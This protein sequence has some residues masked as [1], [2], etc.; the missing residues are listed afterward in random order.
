LPYSQLFAVRQLIAAWCWRLVAGGLIVAAGGLHLA[1]LLH[2]CPLDLAPDEAHY[3]DWSRHLDWSYYSKGPLVAYLIRA[4]VG[5]AGSWSQRMCGSEMPAVRLPAIA[6]GSLL[7]VSL[8]VL[9]LQVYQRERLSVTVVALALTIPL[10]AAGSTLMTIDSP[11]VCCWGWALVLGHRAVLGRSAWAWPAA[12]LVIGLGILAKYTMLLWLPSLAL[13]LL[14]APQR[15]EL[16]LRPGF[17]VMT[18][19]AAV[20]CVPILSWNATHDWVSLRHVAR[21]AGLAEGEAAIRWFGPFVYLGTQF[22][23]MLGF[24]FVAWAAAMLQQPLC[25]EHDPGASY[26]WWMSAPTFIF[27]LLFSLKTPE[28]PNWPLTAYLSG[29]VLTV[30]WV[31]RRLQE[32]KGRPRRWT[33]VSLASACGLGLVVLAFMHHSEWINPVVVGFA[34]PSTRERPLP[35]RR[36]DP[37]CRLRGWRTLAAEVDRLRGLLR[38]ESVEA[39]LATSGWALPGELAFYCEGHP[40]VYSLGL[41]LGDR[42]SQYDLWHPNPLAESAL[43]HGR[44]FI[45]VGEVSELVRQAFEQVDAPRLVLHTERGQPLAQWTVTVCRGFRGM[46]GTAVESLAAGHDAWRSW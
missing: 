30:A 31:A 40:V 2:D 37:T 33:G 12:G 36:F 14:A 10:F 16:L 21:Q 27:F 42:H 8:Y 6:C 15:R 11:Y 28:E 7:L 9:T 32:S 1:Y 19:T 18:G 43:F 29:F 23:V 22:A 34:G 44:T 20:C 39:D 24:W 45:F 13:Y 25:N 5:L 4:S 35:L 26:L 3:W 46:G 17:W 41:A 38:R